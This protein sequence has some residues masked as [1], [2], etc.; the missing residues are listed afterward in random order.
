V[1]PAQPERLG[2]PLAGDGEEFEEAAYA[3]AGVQVP[4]TDEEA[5]GETESEE[6]AQV[7]EKE[8]EAGDDAR[9]SQA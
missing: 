4:E 8:P 5:E 6:G 7:V 9:Q 1:L 3:A 2:D